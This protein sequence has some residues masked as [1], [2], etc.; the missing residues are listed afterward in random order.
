MSAVSV[1]NRQKE[2]YRGLPPVNYDLADAVKTDVKFK[3]FTHPEQQFGK[4]LTVD[5]VADENLDK[6]VPT[7]L[8]IHGWTTDDTSPWYQPLKD[9][10]FRLCPHNVIYVNWWLAGGKTYEVSSANAKPVGKYVA[11]FLLKSGVPLENIH[12]IGKK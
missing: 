5:N 9:V 6:T 4:M 3:V 12:L 8:L 11:C 7:I 2:F 1:M 10:C